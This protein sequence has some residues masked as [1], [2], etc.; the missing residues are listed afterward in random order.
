MPISICAELSCRRRGG[1]N[2]NQ[3]NVGNA[4]TNFFNTHRRH[5]AGV[6]RLD[7]GGADA[8]L[9]RDR[10]RL[11]AD[12]LRRHEP[13]HG[14]DDRS[15]HRRA[16]R[17]ASAP[18]AARP[19]MPTRRAGLCAGK[20]AR[21]RARCLCRDLHQGAAD[22]RPSSSAG[23]CGRR[24]S[25]ARRPPT[26]TPR[27]DRTTPHSTHLRHRRRRRLS[28]LAEHAGR[29]C[30]G[31]RRHQ[32]QRRQ[33]RHRPLRPVPG[34]RLHPAHMRR[35]LSHRRAGLWLAGH[36]HR[37]HRDRRR[38]RPAA[39]RVQRQCL[40]RAASRAAIASS[41]RGSAASASRPMPPGSSRPSICR[42]MP[43][44]VVVRRQHFCARLRRQERHRHRAAN[45]ACAPTNPLR[46]RTASSRCAAAPPG[47]TTSIPTAAIGATF[48]TLPGAS[49]V[50]N[51]AAQAADAAL[52]TGLR[53]N[54]MDQ[55][56]VGGR[57][58][59]GR[60]LRRHPQSYAGKGVVRYAW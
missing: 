46:C 22:A 44:S 18:A 39:R 21:S 45:S 11:A 36:H 42:P 6:R 9:R 54:E 3:Q 38:R 26:A 29:L 5:S 40:V 43:N 27:S 50:V 23:A 33:W 32:F 30:A 31:R 48:Q 20:R 25:A 7:A 10:D 52:A 2:G 41:R 53:G 14:R 15:V 28:L 4:L 16:R 8:G 49:F 37:S 56:L 59:R 51:G 17:S 57:D 34:R 47:R 58:L 1:L 55:R 24:A 35:G 60:V 13:V 12:H 19:A